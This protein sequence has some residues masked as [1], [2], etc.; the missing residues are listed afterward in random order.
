[1]GP[2]FPMGLL[3]TRERTISEKTIDKID[4]RGQVDLPT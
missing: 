4:Y 3:E 1:M 2:D